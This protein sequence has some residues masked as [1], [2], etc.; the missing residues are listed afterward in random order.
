M[1]AVRKTLGVLV[2]LLA[3]AGVLVTVVLAT[4]RIDQRPRTDDAY[5]QADLVHMA[6]EVSGRIIELDVRDNQA[7]H[8]GDV[9]FR[10]DPE[11]YKMRVDQA[12]AAVRGL[13]AKLGLTADQVAAQTSKADAAASGISTAEAQRALA[14]STLARMEP[15]LGH[16]FVTAQQVD[17][18]RTAQRTAQLGLQ[19]A[20]LQADEARQAIINT[21]PTE[22]ELEGGQATLALAERD[23]NKTVVRAPCDGRITALDIAAGEFAVTG[24]PL[25][26]IIDTEHWYAIG[27]FRETD[28]AGIEPGQ[29]ATVYVLAQPSRPVSGK[30]DSLG[31]GVASDVSATFGG[32]PHVERTLN[33]V[34]IA[35]RFPVRVLLDAPPDD[36]MRYGATAVIV[37]DK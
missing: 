13:E 27:N 7:V 2:S 6:P 30:V 3:L 32:L 35:A 21:K 23:L 18:A 25:F 8:K 4:R 1:L 19:Q 15:L 20:R 29:H 33:W 16:G 14:T 11:P 28:L 9:L 22:A 37:I 5:L 17:Q 31:W 12:R 34:R 10:I 24:H 26:T 36:L